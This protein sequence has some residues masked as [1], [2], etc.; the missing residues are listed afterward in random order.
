LKPLLPDG[1]V[2]QRLEFLENQ[3]LAE[4]VDRT[5]LHRLDRDLSAPFAADHDD[6]D[7]GV[8]TVQPSQDFQAIKIRQLEVQQHDVRLEALELCQRCRAAFG[9]ARVEAGPLEK[10]LNVPREPRLVFDD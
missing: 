6:L 9:I 5:G 7:A 4:I 3:G 2:E 8:G 10:G 1:F